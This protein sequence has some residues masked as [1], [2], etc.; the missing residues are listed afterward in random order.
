[1]RVGVVIPAFNESATVGAVVRAL[2]STASDAHEIVTVRVVDNGSSDKTAAEAVAA[3]AQVVFEQERGY[4]AACLKG[5]SS[6]RDTG[7]DVVLFV[8]ADGSDRPAEWPTLVDPIA[9]DEADLVIGSRLLGNAEPGALQPHQRFG[10]TLATTL[11]A[12]I[13]SFR[14][15][16]LGPFRAITWS[17][18]E[19]LRMQDRNYGWTVE[20]QLRA[21]RL[22]FRCKEVPVSYRMRQGG[23]SK[24]S[25]TVLGSA[26]AGTKILALVGREFFRK[27]RTV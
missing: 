24:V 3:G 16:D 18:L 1:M 15:T 5:I 26:R 23:R 14:F 8:D 19:A 4:G 13:Y 6:L 27:Q 11:M 10:N 12:W 17:A 22:G 20:M 7:V 21:L 9:A 25:G 2:L